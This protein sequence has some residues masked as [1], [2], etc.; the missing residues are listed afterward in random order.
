MYKVSITPEADKG[1]VRLAKSEPKLYQK[2]QK[3][4]EE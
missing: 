4:I 2:V 1:F 3:F